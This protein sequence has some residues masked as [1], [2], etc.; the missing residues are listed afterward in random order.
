MVKAAILFALSFVAAVLLACPYGPGIAGSSGTP[1]DLREIIRPF[2]DDLAPVVSKAIHLAGTEA[3]RYAD[4]VLGL[5][6]QA[7]YN[8]FI[9]Q[10]PRD[11]APGSWDHVHTVNPEDLKRW[12][13]VREAWHAYER[14][15]KA[16]GYQ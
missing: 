5:Q 4:G 14:M 9:Y 3:H 1:G 2:T 11:K 10:H 6:F 12:Q 7:L 8:D 13:R 16:A 15:M